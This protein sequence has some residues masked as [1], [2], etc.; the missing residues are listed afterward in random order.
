MIDRFLT[1][2]EVERRYSPLT[3]R[4]YRHDIE[5]FAAW[6]Q[7]HHNL[8]TFDV[9]QLS[10]TDLR[11][12]IVKRID[13]DK[14][15]PASINRELSSLRSFLRYMRRIG[16]VDKDLFKFIVSLRTPTVLPT[17]VPETRM[18]RVLDNCNDDSESL[19][20]R[21]Q[22]RAL[23]I[24][25]FYGCGLRL[26]ELHAL[27]LGDI[28]LAGATI[29]VVGKGD[30]ERLLPLLATLVERIKRYIDCVAKEGVEVT[31][32]MPLIVTE[33]GGALSRSSIQRAVASALGE[34]S[35]Q[36]RKSPHVL[37]HTFAT[38]LLNRD[39]DMRDIQELL[40]HSSMRTTQHYTHNNIAALQRIYDKAHPHGRG[41][42][43]KKGADSQ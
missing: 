16:S 8:P 21:D 6:W 30:K 25:M 41:H 2:I 36:G 29:R 39:A 18:R 43:G 12:W 10:A 20:F 34:A 7:Q 11:E 4:N 28:D 13:S 35:V 40:G 42:G 19:S 31:N 9:T 22:R 23:I 24:A 15:K 5:L 38:H 32:A 14:A 26:G 17:F 3:V 1:Y 37:R 33:Q 27:R